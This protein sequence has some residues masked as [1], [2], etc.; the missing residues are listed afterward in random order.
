MLHF[1]TALLLLFAC[2]HAGCVKRPPAERLDRQAPVALSVV[3]PVYDGCRL[4]GLLLVRA[5][6]EVVVDRRLHEYGSISPYRISDCATGR[7]IDYLFV[8]YVTES[9]TEDELLLLRAGEV[10]GRNVSFRLF[11]EAL[12]MVPGPSCIEYELSFSIP[13]DKGRGRDAS[14]DGRVDRTA[15]PKACMP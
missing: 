2:L 11:S 8:D 9:A 10:F 3:E 1:S 5:L 14:V 15:E 6:G 12:D 4:Q 13:G 7:Q